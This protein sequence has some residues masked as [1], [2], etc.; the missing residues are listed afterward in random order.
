M[1]ETGAGKHFLWRTEGMMSAYE[2]HEPAPFGDAREFQ[3]D[4]PAF[5]AQIIFR[6]KMMPWPAPNSEFG[7][8][9]E[10]C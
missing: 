10:P 6:S 2:I 1:K 7:R 9:V 8:K 5:P 3:F 4:S